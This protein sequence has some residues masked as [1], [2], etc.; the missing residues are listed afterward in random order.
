MSQR[1][2][3]VPHDLTP[4]ADKALQQA[5]QLSNSI[6]SKIILVHIVQKQSEIENAEKSL[7]NIINSHSK[8][9]IEYVVKKGS[10][11]TDIGK[12]ADSHK[13][14]AIIMGTHG[15]KGMQKVFG[16]FAMKVII[17]TSVPFM[18]IQ[19][20]TKLKDINKICL[21]IEAS[22]ESMQIMSLAGNLAKTY[23]AKVYIIAEKE[24]DIKI[25]KKIKNNLTIISKHMQKNSVNFHLELLENNSS[26]DKTVQKYAA[27]NSIDMFAYSYNSDRFLAS[28]DKFSQSL[29]FNES[30]I[31]ALIINAKKITASTYF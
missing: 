25:A 10:I 31:P 4:V 11:F 5:I 22:S 18:V 20:G 15:A 21:S 17:S 27:S 24:K 19:E 9:T 28:N 8:H 29:L 12:L 16:S 6:E 26:W 23:S 2:F 7:Q 14:T 3:I 30:K 13:A 1:I